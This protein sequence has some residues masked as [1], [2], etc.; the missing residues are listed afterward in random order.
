MDLTEQGI[1]EARAAGR[2]LADEQLELDE[3]TDACRAQLGVLRLCES[4]AK[5]FWCRVLGFLSPST[6]EHPAQH[7]VNSTKLSQRLTRMVSDT[8]VPEL[9]FSLPTGARLV[10]PPDHPLRRAHAVHA[11]AVLG[12]GLQAPAPE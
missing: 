7:V 9:P 11:Q 3:V 4:V 2:L 8:L 10:P 1:A 5:D 12:A 6:S